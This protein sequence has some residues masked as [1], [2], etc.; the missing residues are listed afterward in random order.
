MVGRG[1]PGEGLGEDNYKKRDWGDLGELRRASWGKGWEKMGNCE[2][3]RWWKDGG[4]ISILDAIPS[5]ER[6]LGDI[7][8]YVKNVT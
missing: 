1:E 2:G 3:N 8:L 4:H 6:G 5:S 7:C